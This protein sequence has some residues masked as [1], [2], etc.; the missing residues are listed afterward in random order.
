MSGAHNSQST[1]VPARVLALQFCIT[2]GKEDNED[3]L[4]SV[5][6]PVYALVG[7]I[8]TPDC[9][10]V[11]DAADREGGLSHSINPHTLFT[12]QVSSVGIQ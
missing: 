9:L 11:S 1:M 2:R 8:K 7:H 6:I 5:I 4:H 12:A 10:S 3:T